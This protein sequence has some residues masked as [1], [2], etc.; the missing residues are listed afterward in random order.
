MAQLY[1]NP[2]QNLGAVVRGE[3]P[4]VICYSS[5]IGDSVHR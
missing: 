4:E 3:T 2:V 5:G 1:F